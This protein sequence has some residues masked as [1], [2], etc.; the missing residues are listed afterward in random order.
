MTKKLVLF[1]LYKG[2][3]M[4]GFEIFCL[5]PSFL[6]TLRNSICFQ[7]LNSVLKINLVLDRVNRFFFDNFLK[8][9][10]FM[11]KKVI[12]CWLSPHPNY[13]YCFYILN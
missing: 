10:H 11:T 1:Y 5:V 13:Y 9:Q 8:C 2:R 6:L 4:N 3:V 7:T 12:Y